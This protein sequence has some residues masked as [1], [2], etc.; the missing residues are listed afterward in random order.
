MSKNQSRIDFEAAGLKLGL[1]QGNYKKDDSGDYVNYPTQCYWEFWQA[2]RESIVVD[3]PDG[4][5]T[6]DGQGFS[7]DG[8]RT[9]EALEAVGVMVRTNS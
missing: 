6:P 9:F 1:R 3:L 8:F 5:P 7:L 4:S 2:A